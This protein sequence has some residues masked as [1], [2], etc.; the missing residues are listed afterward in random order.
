MDYYNIL[1]LEKNAS[2]QEIKQAYRKLAS[3]HHPD[4][5]GDTTKFQSLQQAYDTLIDPE[6]RNQYDNGG[7]NNNPFGNNPFGNIKD[8]FNFINAQQKIYAAQLQI[9]LEQLAIGSV[10]NIQIMTPE[11]PKTVQIKLPKGI[12]NGSTVRYNVMN[13]AHLQIT[14]LVKPHDIFE[15]NG[16]NL[17][18]TVTLDIWDLIIGTKLTTK[19]IYNNLIEVNIPPMTKIGSKFKIQNQGLQNDHGAVGD[20]FIITQAML[21]NAISNSL[22]E[23]IKKENQKNAQS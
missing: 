5:G 3:L 8:F 20:F 13:N 23:L 11:G 18:Q 14:F 16:L 4:K 7:L 2:A 6:K 9:T 17:I 15:R 10:E 19:T 1:G 12:E 22:L 21:P